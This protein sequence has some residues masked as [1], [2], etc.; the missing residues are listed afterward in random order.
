MCFQRAPPAYSTLMQPSMNH[1][2]CKPDLLIVH[3]NYYFNRPALSRTRLHRARVPSH[4]AA[5]RLAWLCLRRK[6]R[7]PRGSTAHAPHATPQCDSAPPENSVTNMRR[8]CALTHKMVGGIKA[9]VFVMSAL[10]F[11]DLHTVLVA[12]G[13]VRVGR[14]VGCWSTRCALLPLTW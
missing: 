8:D 2:T 9:S 12:S 5:L 10:L 7:T 4:K 13:Y 11:L 6:L 3:N 1:L 14:Y